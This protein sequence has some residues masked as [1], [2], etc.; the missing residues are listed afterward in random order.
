MSNSFLVL[1]K[2][3]SFLNG[4]T[5]FFSIFLF[6][7]RSI[8]TWIWR[9]YVCLLCWFGNAREMCIINGWWISWVICK[10]LP[11]GLFSLPMRFLLVSFGCLLVLKLSSFINAIVLYWRFRNERFPYCSFFSFR[12]LVLC[13]TFFHYTFCHFVICISL[14]NICCKNLALGFFR[15]ILLFDFLNFMFLSSFSYLHFY[16]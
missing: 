4:R 3:L 16:K 8:Q 11:N 9:I 6:E 14:K 13:F 7:L 15:N 2:N 5:F 1:K 10:H 12:F